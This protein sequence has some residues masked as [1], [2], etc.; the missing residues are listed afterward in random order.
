[1]FG[2]SDKHD[3]PT[4]IEDPEYGQL[5][6][7]IMKR[8]Q[9]GAFEYEMLDVEPCTEAYIEENMFKVEARHEGRQKANMPKLKC[10]DLHGDPTTI[11]GDFSTAG[12]TMLSIFFASCDRLNI[13][14]CKKPEEVTAWLKHKY[15]LLYYTEDRASEASPIDGVQ[16]TTFEQIPVNRIVDT[17]HRF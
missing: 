7:F 9:E 6:P 17:N 5:I 1:M 12:S 15:V 8:N 16:Y 13:A 2:L 11:F 4:P 14:T 3:S 10:L